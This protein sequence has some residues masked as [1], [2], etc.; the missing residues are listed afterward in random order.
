MAVDSPA[1]I[2]VIGA[3][4]IGLEAALYARFLGYR[5]EIYERGGVAEHVRQWDHVRMFSPF[6]L[7]RSTLGIAAI[8]AQ[9]PGY[10]APDDDAI[11]TGAEWFQQYLQPLSQTDLLVDHLHTQT[12]VRAV[13][14]LEHRKTDW[15][16]D[17][18]RRESE[19]RLLLENS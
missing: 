14:R 17:P 1:D 13:A 11:L 8:A 5:V 2:A 4:P 15:V 18:L 10:Q 12:Q 19:F 16:G 3:G 7:N 6:K 9:D